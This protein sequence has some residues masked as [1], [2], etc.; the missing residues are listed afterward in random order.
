MNLVTQ[1]LKALF[2][3]NINIIS[4]TFDGA[5]ANF[6]MANLLGCSLKLQNIKT[7]FKSENHIVQILP[8]LSHMIKLV[9]N[10]F[11]EKKIMIDENGDIIDYTLI[12]KLCELQETEGL[13]LANKLRRQQIHFFKQKMKVKLA[14]QLLSRSVAESLKFC[15]DKLNLNDFKN[16]DATINFV[17][18]MNDAFDILNSHYLSGYGPKKRY[19]KKIYNR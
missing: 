4:L 3:C 16:C 17:I 18:I 10:T 8:D 1:C 12:I 6:V 13:H 15:K 14:V 11:G 2:D 9:R 19:A 7:S 5:Q